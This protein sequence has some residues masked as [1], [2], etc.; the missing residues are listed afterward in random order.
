MGQIL[1]KGTTGKGSLPSSHSYL[2]DLVPYRLLD[3]GHQFHA[4][5]WPGSN[6]SSLLNGLLQY[7]I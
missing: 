6:F 5:C 4:D 1:P 7:G 3:Q 2:Q